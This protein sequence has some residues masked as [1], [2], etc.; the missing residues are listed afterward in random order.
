MHA[1]LSALHDNMEP[2]MMA[3][4]RHP[5]LGRRVDMSAPN[6][7]TRTVDSPVSLLAAGW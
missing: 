1:G 7:A 4:Q 3:K 2:W 6:L 5:Q